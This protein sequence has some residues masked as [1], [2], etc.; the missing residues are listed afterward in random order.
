M[1]KIWSAS[2]PVFLPADDGLW[3]TIV[4]DPS[5]DAKDDREKKR[6]KRMREAKA[7]RIAVVQRDTTYESWKLGERG[8]RKVV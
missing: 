5:D 3:L 2:P 1:E 7:A 4:H 8:S 6:E